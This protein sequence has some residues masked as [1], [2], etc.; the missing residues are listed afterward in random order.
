MG[1]PL[2][3]Y[4]LEC[5]AE[6]IANVLLNAWGLENVLEFV[7]EKSYPP[8]PRSE[9]DS[10]MEPAGGESLMPGRP[11]ATGSRNPQLTSCFAERIQNPRF[12]R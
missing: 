7:F 2:L 5:A 8:L 1:A 9:G 6:P 4:R 3:A 10:E 12:S 11:H